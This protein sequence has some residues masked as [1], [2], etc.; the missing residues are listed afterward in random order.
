M[1]TT[2]SPRS[3]SALATW[4]PMNPA[5]PVRR[6]DMRLL[7]LDDDPAADRPRAAAWPIASPRRRQGLSCGDRVLEAA[8]EVLEAKDEARL[9]EDLPQHRLAEGRE[10]FLQPI[11]TGHEIINPGAGLEGVPD[12][13]GV[14]D[15]TW[16]FVPIAV[17]ET[18]LIGVNAVAEPKI[19]KI[20]DDPVA[21]ASSQQLGS[22]FGKA[23]LDQQPV[24]G[25]EELARK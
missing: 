16:P 19:V 23:A 9:L 14:G 18:A 4:N 7:A 11:A 25:L 5:A 3:S 15:E 2:R 24:E 21:G 20:A 17:G 22:A 13:Q 12:R 6:I 1:P 10:A 8:A